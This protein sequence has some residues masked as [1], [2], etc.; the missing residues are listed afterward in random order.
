MP[1][2]H[3]H[4]HTSKQNR[5]LKKQM[6]Q[7]SKKTG[8]LFEEVLHRPIGQ[9]LP[10]SGKSLLKTLPVFYK[11]MNLTSGIFFIILAEERFSLFTIDDSGKGIKWETKHFFFRF[12]AGAKKGVNES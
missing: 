7:W 5:G 12:T 9:T 1:G 11:L 6:S 2:Q 10:S 8:Q 3:K 4:Q